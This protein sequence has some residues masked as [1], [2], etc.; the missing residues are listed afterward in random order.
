VRKKMME[1][2][3]RIYWE[4]NEEESVEEKKKKNG[5]MKFIVVYCVSTEWRLTSYPEWDKL[6]TEVII[7]V[8][9]FHFPSIILYFLL[10]FLHR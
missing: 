4:K 8:C 7:P 1:R 6:F 10:V 5:M 3:E 9:F 2:K